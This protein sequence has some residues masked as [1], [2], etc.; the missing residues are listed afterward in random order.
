MGS[1]HDTAADVRLV[2]ATNRDLTRDVEEGR[3]RRDLYFRIA[4]VTVSLPPLRERPGDI[5]P[6]TRHLLGRLAV[7]H[8]IPLAEITAEALEALARHAWPGNVRELRNVLER[9]LVVRGGAPIRAADLAL[10][11]GPA[12]GGPARPAPIPLGREEWERE[13]LL[14]ALRKSGGNRTRAAALLGVSLRT[15]YYRLKKLKLT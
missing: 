3:F 12:S 6:L 11:L 5:E 14:E 1:A 10:D 9:A 7:R 2:A 13:S 15:L 8:G 4:V